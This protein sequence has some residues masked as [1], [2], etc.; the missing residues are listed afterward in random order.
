[1]SSWV[2]CANIEYKFVDPERI[3]PPDNVVA[4][5][6]NAVFVPLVDKFASV[7]EVIFTVGAFPVPPVKVFVPN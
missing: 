7:A 2:D 3:V 5:K 1:M 6:P 4:E